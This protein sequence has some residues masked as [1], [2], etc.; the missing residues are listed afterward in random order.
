MKVGNADRSHE[1]RGPDRLIEIEA[2]HR[3]SRTTE[4]EVSYQIVDHVDAVEIRID[5]EPGR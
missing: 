5:T 1:Q 4:A 2:E 3:N